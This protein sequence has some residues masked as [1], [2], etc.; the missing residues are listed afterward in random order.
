M[1]ICDSSDKGEGGG[2]SKSMAIIGAACKGNNSGIMVR[3]LGILARTP[4]G[5]G[6]KG[7]GTDTHTCQ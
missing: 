7:T 3:A 5:G 4:L 6:K 1:G 2:N